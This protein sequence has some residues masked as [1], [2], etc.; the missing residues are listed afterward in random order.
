[1]DYMYFSSDQPNDKPVPVLVSIDRAAGYMVASVCRV[2]GQADT[3][4]V[5]ACNRFLTEAGLNG[6]IRMRSDPE[7]AARAAA[8]AVATRR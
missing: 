5:R 7:M 4:S 1:M 8:Q 6:T 2:K 3:A